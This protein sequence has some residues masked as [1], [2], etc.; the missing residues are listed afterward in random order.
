[1]APVSWNEC[2]S[3]NN[4]RE[5]SGRKL[6]RNGFERAP[7]SESKTPSAANW[8]GESFGADTNRGGKLT[9]VAGGGGRGKDKC[10]SDCDFTDLIDWLSIATNDGFISLSLSLCVSQWPFSI[11]CKPIINSGKQS[12]LSLSMAE[13]EEGEEGGRDRERE[14]SASTQIRFCFCPRSL[15]PPVPLWREITITNSG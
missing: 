11:P 3:G 9:E 10:W 14:T 8:M 6:T 15:L 12:Q 1:M 7:S 4:V 5:P 2:H 13:G